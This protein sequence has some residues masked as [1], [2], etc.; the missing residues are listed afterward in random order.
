[1]L[2]TCIKQIVRKE[3][4]TRSS[5]ERLCD[6]ALVLQLDPTTGRVVGPGNAAEDLDGAKFLLNY[7]DGHQRA[8]LR[9]VYYD[10]GAGEQTL[11]TAWSDLGTGKPLVSGHDVYDIYASLFINENVIAIFRY[12]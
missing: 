5:V 2:I 12:S 4:G 1:M 9:Q 3:K 7:L 8:R 10:I 6:E 11:V